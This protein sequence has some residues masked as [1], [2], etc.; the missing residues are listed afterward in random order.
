M[1]NWWH[2]DKGNEKDRNL[3]TRGW[4]GIRKQWQNNGRMMWD[5]KNHEEGTKKDGKAD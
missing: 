2:D 1:G 3:T 4:Q 5:N